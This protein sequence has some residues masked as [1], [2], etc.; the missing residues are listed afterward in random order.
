MNQK[1]IN[2]L[3]MYA[4]RRA[5]RALQLAAIRAHRMPSENATFD[6]TL[7]I[8]KTAANTLKDLPSPSPEAVRLMVAAMAISNGTKCKNTV[9]ALLGG[10]DNADDSKFDWA[11]QRDFPG[12][13]VRTYWDYVFRS[14][15]Y[16]LACE[17]EYDC[18][19][20]FETRGVS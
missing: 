18:A 16:S 8:A 2:A 6:G 1:Q 14:S 9:A 13:S 5:E 20:F 3:M 10:A 17:R 7:Q 12:Y 19:K 15:A 4:D 11:A